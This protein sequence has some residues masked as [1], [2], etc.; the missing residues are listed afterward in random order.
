MTRMV[1]MMRRLM[2]T[3]RRIMLWRQKHCKVGTGAACGDGRNS[4]MVCNSPILY[5]RIHWSMYTCTF[6]YTY[7]YTL[8]NTYHTHYTTQIIT[9]LDINVMYSPVLLKVQCTNCSTAVH[10]LLLLQMRIVRGVVGATCSLHPNLKPSGVTRFS[11]VFLNRT[12]VFLFFST[13][14][15]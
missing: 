8:I 12:S 13:I 1:T 2:V 9:Q 3:R 15:L 11:T 10:T 7:V 5:K 4:R 14:F 6:T